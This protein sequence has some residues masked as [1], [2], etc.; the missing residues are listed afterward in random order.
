MNEINEVGYINRWFI[1]ESLHKCENINV[2]QQVR[3]M[4][5]YNCRVHKLLK[6]HH[7]KFK[8]MVGNLF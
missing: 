2:E 6:E 7:S 5:I 1:R 3:L 8:C 4:K